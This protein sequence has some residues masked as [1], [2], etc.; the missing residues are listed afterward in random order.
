MKPKSSFKRSRIGRFAILV[1]LPYD[2]VAMQFIRVYSDNVVVSYI[3]KNLPIRSNSLLSFLTTNHFRAY[4]EK[5]DSVYGDNVIIYVEFR[6]FGIL[7]Y[8]MTKS[9]VFCPFINRQSRFV[10]S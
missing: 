6:R 3:R 4:D 1:I 10:I 7:T 8:G 9:L 5:I 2:L